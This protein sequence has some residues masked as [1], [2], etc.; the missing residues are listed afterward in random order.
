M[1]PCRQGW[2][3]H[4]GL[5]L[6]DGIGIVLAPV[7]GRSDA[8]A[9][10][11]PTLPCIRGGRARERRGIGGGIST[12][13]WP[14]PHASRS[15]RTSLC[16]RCRRSSGHRPAH[17]VYRILKGDLRAVGLRDRGQQ[18]RGALIPIRRDIGRIGARIVRGGVGSNYDR[19]QAV[20]RVVGV[21]HPLLGGSIAHLADVG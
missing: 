6:R 19:C 14:R 16:C 18:I 1:Q 3:A 5:Q 15:S 13:P 12:A 20:L 4:V 17:P 2:V 21:L 8:R 7:H 11:G 10:C 9:R